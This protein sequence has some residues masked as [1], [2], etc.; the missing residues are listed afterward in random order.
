MKHDRWVL[1]L[2]IHKDMPP[3]NIAASF[4]NR[5]VLN[6]LKYIFTPSPFHAKTDVLKAII[7]RYLKQIQPL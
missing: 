3:N 7:Y 5:L 1:K 6:N 4:L 2:R